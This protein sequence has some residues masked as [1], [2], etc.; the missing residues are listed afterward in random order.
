[1]HLTMM[2]AQVA[3]VND[4]LTEIPGTWLYRRCDVDLLRKRR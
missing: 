3:D 2:L 1:M 4:L